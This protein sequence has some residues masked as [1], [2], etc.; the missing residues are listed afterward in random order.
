VAA[1]YGDVVDLPV[2]GMT[3]TLLSHPDH[4]H[5]V[6][7]AHSAQ[8]KKIELAQALMF[9]E[10]PA[11]PLLHGHEW[12]R[13]RL[14][15]SPFFAERA[16]RNVTG[17][18]VESAVAQVER[19]SAFADTDEYVDLEHKIGSVVMSALL[20]SMFRYDADAASVDRWV[21]MATDYG[22]AVVAQGPFYKL[23]GWVPRPKQRMGQAAQQMFMRLLDDMIATRLGEEHDPDQ[24]GDV[25]DVLLAMNFEGTPEMQYRRMRSE[26]SGLVFAGFDT[27]AEAVAWTLAFLCRTP[28]AAGKAYAEVDTLG[29]SPLTFEHT[30]ELPYLRACFDEAQ[31]LQSAPANMRTATVDD[32]IGGY[33]IPAGSH[34]VI[35]PLGLQTDPRFWPDPLVYRPE[36]W[37]TDKINFNAYVPFSTGPR[38]CMGVHKAY[39][40]GPLILAAI[41]R[42]Y[43][44][45]VRD[46][47]VPKHVLHTSIGLKGGLPVRLHSR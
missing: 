18:M 3:V 26:L 14:A 31:R 17:M 9:G 16:M 42:R 11:L 4:L 29:D 6:W 1:V 39:I 33:H 2:P 22:A 28:S 12:R 5:H 20:R 41:L 47:W 35:S 15:L 43:T 25:L 19:W 40:D 45:Q 10:P 32:E 21:Q 38:K 37:F 36:R 23:P 27:T 24:P 8:Y 13:T 30:K 46:G 44:L 7:V 34:V